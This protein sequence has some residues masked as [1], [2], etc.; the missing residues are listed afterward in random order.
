[1]ARKLPQ[2]I[3]KEDFD[4]LLEAVK[5]E[6][7]EH[8]MPRKEEYKPTG[9]RLQ[10]FLIAICFGFGAGMRISEICGLKKKQVYTYKKK[11]QI[12]ATTQTLESNI[13]PLTPK[14]IENNMVRVKMGKG[15]KDRTVPLP[16]KTLRR[17]GITRADLDKL[18]PLKTSY[19]TIEKLITRYGE[20]VLGKHITFHMLR[21]GFVSHALAS[22]MAIHQVQAFAGHS[23]MDTTGL[24]A[25]VNPKQ[26]LDKYGEIDF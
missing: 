26:A 20:Q 10:D 18:L 23:R 22:G 2:P 1:M 6:R 9:K 19:R 8:W 4:K 14:S 12:E 25:H 24:Y 15:G 16:T 13:E 3:L 11:G 17:A 7:D 5:K 21:H